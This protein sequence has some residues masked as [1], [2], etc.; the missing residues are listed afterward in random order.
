MEDSEYRAALM[1]L[2]KLERLKTDL[3]KQL[4]QRAPDDSEVKK[5]QQESEEIEQGVNDLIDRSHDEFHRLPPGVN[6]PPEWKYQYIEDL[7][8][9]LDNV[10]RRQAFGNL[11]DHL[12][13]GPVRLHNARVEQDLARRRAEA[14]ARRSGGDAG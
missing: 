9:R 8:V 5:L 13:Y 4:R 3:S 1:Q 10:N 6:P 2:K 11:L 14:D 12:H 7:F